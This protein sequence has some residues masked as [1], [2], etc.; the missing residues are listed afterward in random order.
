MTLTAKQRV[1]IDRYVELRNGAHA[2]VAAGYAVGSA[3]ITASRLL[4]RDNVRE[5]LA[6]RQAVAAHE[7][8]ITRQRVLDGL[9]EAIASAKANMDPAAQIRGWAE[10]AKML[11]YNAPETKHVVLSA[12]GDRRRAELE[13]LSD[14]ELLELVTDSRD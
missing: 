12:E 10:V 11:G 5:A 3:R 8:R 9:L 2:A 1:F 6:E 4:T 14:A 7:A 13:A